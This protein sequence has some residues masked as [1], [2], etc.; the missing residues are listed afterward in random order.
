MCDAKRSEVSRGSYQESYRV[1]AGKGDAEEVTILSAYC[2]RMS[3]MS[4]HTR[5]SRR[6]F[7]KNWLLCTN[8]SHNVY[9]GYGFLIGNGGKRQCP[10]YALASGGYTR[11]RFENI[12]ENINDQRLY[13]TSR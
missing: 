12:Q 10:A 5:P 8:E 7:S 1:G 4:A 6:D 2:K 13:C 9:S 3:T 11:V